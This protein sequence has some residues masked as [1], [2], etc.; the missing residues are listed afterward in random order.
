MSIITVRCR[1][2]AGVKQQINKKSI[3]N[4]SAEEQI[5][6]Q[7]LLDENKDEDAKVKAKIKKNT[8]ITL[9]E[10][11][12]DVRQQLWH[13]FL[14]SSSLTDKL[15]DRLSQH[16]NFQTWLQQGNLP[17]DEL[18]ACWLELKTSPLYDEKLPGRFFSS[19]Q[20][21]VKI[22]YA[23]WLA[24]HQQ[25][26]RRF[27]GLNRLT[28]IV[29]SDEALLEMCDLTFAQLQE[30]AESMLSE[31]DKEIANSEKLLSRINL[32]FTKHAELPEEDITSRSAIAYLIR[33]GCK[34]EP[35][36]ESTE[37]FK[38]WFRTKR[39][40]ARRLE[41]QLAGHFP[42]GRD[43]QDKTLKSCLENINRDDFADDLEYML[44]HNPISRN[45]PP[46]PHPI[47]F[48]TNTDLRWFK[49]Y[50][51][52]YKCKRTATGK[53]IDSI[54]LTQRL[55]VEFNGL[56]KGTNYVFEVYC[57]RRQLPL[58][59][60]FFKD[61]Q[62][63]LKPNKQDNKQQETY[64]S[65]LFILRSAHLLWE[66]QEF[67]DRY[68]HKSLT[69]QTANE[70]WNTHQLYL[71]C[72][73]ETD[74]LTAEGT[75]K[76]QQQKIQKANNTIA[77]QS[78]NDNP[79][80]KEQQSLKKNQTSLAALTRSLPR[81]NS[82]IAQVNPQIIVG[83]IFDPVK[84]IYLAVVDVITGKTVAYRSTR[85]LLGKKY[86]KLSEYRLKQQ[87]NSRHRR[88][89]NQKGQFRQLT[90]STQGEHLDRLLAKAII[91]VAQEFKA[92]SIAL[93]PVNNRIE[94]IQSEL[95]AYAEEEIPEDIGTQ[96][97]LTRKTS[98][99]IHKWSYN[100]LSGNIRSNAAKLNIAVEMGA[101]PSRGTLAEQATAIAMSAYN[102]RQHSNR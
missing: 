76:I 22:I 41:K 15:L 36:I 18:K 81:P 52:Q 87:H 46:L 24:L 33:H 51:K 56:T 65:G 100:R 43:V 16:P 31:I 72:A 69:T 10:S 61:Y 63:N 30:N 57:D 4:S 26:Q 49:L 11:S 71:H 39:K 20:S 13:F 53:S 78:T 3:E 12:E 59:Q 7:N 25:K 42:R 97:E 28:E 19:V 92:A 77:K 94:K 70:P 101:L 84:P 50:R 17:D 88:K 58:F 32:L 5:L 80:V 96:Q 73:I 29:Y 90:E 83:L 98:V 2:V 34:I 35:K 37:K 68:R 99:A 54:E 38:K 14:T 86:L 79:N 27:D 55:F 93:P 48:N 64:S 91:K 21:M 85:Q 1:L 67:Q 45:A 8:F 82:P 9:A 23:S 89:Q 74:L 75:S 6:L 102:S 44:W 66:R 95:E 62:L 47:E 40:E 60:H